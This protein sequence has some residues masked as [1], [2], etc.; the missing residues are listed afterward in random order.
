MRGVWRFGVLALTLAAGL[1]CPAATRAQDPGTAVITSPLAGATLN[2]IV[3][4]AGSA[5]HP[6]FQR[7][8]LAF[9]YSPNLTDTWFSLQAPVSGQV[10]NEVLGRWDTTRITDGLYVLRLRVF[11]GENAYL[12]TFVP[13]VL[14]QNSTPTAPAPTPAPPTAV[15]PA[16]STP[17]PTSTPPSI[18]LPPTATQR[19]AV[20]AGGGPGSPASPGTSA[21][22][23][24][25]ASLIGVAFLAG[26]R[27]TLAAFLLLGAYAAMRTALRF[28][29]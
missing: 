13:N 10:V 15:A 28:R 17:D 20:S 24:I 3:P 11:Y 12:E 6:Q 23:R 4:I 2:G 8:E 18:D 19:A 5:A 21:P 7:Y 1:F 26:V 29:R 27:F 22:V 25:N 14:V 9:G 16:A